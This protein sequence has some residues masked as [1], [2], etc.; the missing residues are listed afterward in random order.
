MAVTV[1]SVLSLL[2]DMFPEITNAQAIAYV[3]DANNLILE[4][5]PEMRQDSISV[6]VTAGT[7]AYSVNSSTF[8][9]QYA[10]WTPTSGLSS[11]LSQI[12]TTQL[13]SDVQAWRFASNAPPVNFYITTGIITAA[14]ALEVGLYPPPDTNGTLVLYGSVQGADLTSGDSLPPSYPDRLTHAYGAAYFASVVFR[15]GSSAAYW[16]LFVQHVT[17]LTTFMRSRGN[18]QPSP[19]LLNTRSAGYPDLTARGRK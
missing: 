1:A 10:Q 9:I 5:I 7:S 8:Q 16:S 12:T 6:S 3:N 14:P 13:D 15:F 2:Q 19:D 17:R 4:A 18:D 11:K